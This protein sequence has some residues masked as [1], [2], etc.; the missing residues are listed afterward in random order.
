MFSGKQVQKV[1]ES[2]K[3]HCQLSE[4]ITAVFSKCLYR[5]GKRIK[6]DHMNS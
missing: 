4:I 6:V 2:R 5:I 1:N 3:S